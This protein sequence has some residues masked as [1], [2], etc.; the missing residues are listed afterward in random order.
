[1]PTKKYCGGEE[2][3]LYAHATAQKFGLHARAQFQST[4]TSLKWA[5]N[6]RAWVCQLREHPK[7]DKERDHTVM[8]NFVIL[9]SGIFPGPKVPAFAG[10]DEFKGD[11]FHTSKWDSGVTGGSQN[12]PALDKLMGKR[13]AFVGTGKSFHYFNA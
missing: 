4:V 7:G 1:M 9:A 10:L 11:M 12:K 6:K 3:R 2:I 8:S 13:V 5:N